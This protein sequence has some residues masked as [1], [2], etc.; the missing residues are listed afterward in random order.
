MSRY[1]SG[2]NYDYPDNT[3]GEKYVPVQAGWR[4]IDPNNTEPHD[5]GI[6]RAMKARCMCLS[7]FFF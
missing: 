1:S 3:S 4:T 7:G 2:S 5:H 6:L